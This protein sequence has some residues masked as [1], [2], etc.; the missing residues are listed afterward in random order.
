[1]G[2]E[3]PPFIKERERDVLS[4]NKNVIFC[5]SKIKLLLGKN[6][7]FIHMFEKFFIKNIK[8]I[9]T[10]FYVSKEGEINDN[11]LYT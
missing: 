9:V 6:S 4:F 8:V 10:N 1:L 7:L 11:I 2:E 3:Y 5:L